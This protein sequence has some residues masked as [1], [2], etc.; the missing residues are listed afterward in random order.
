MAN[1]EATQ[2]SQKT[3]NTSSHAWH[4]CGLNGH[5]MIICPKFVEMQEMFHG[6]FVVVA[7]VQHVAEI[8]I[9]IAN[10]YV[11]DVNITTKRTITQEWVFKDK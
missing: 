8:Q 11:V 4:I 10:V 6:K 9:V 5:K 1:R 2:L 7:K 3:Q